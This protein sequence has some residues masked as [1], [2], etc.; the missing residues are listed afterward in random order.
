MFS[1]QQPGKPY[2]PGELPGYNLPPAEMGSVVL[3]PGEV[4]YSP[5]GSVHY[6]LIEEDMVDGFDIHAPGF[7]APMVGR[8]WRAAPQS[9]RTAA[10]QGSAAG[11]QPPSLGA[12]SDTLTR[13]G[14]GRTSTPCTLALAAGDC[15]QLQY[16]RPYGDAVLHWPLWRAHRPHRPAGGPPCSASQALQAECLFGVLVCA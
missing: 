3:G 16:H 12:E 10:P 15:C 9:Q 14:L 13:P 8:E 11:A 6:Y 7:A 5:R 1:A 2:T 4:L